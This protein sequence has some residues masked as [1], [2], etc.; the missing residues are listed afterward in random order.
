M[1]FTKRRPSVILK[2]RSLIKRHLWNRT[3]KMSENLY[4]VFETGGVDF[5]P[6][7]LGIYGTEALAKVRAKEAL[8]TFIPKFA[9]D[10]PIITKEQ[11]DNYT[12]FYIYDSKDD[13]DCQCY[14]NVIVIAEF[15]STDIRD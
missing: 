12:Y 11:V 2:H 15:K 13:Y 8:S 14:I 7:L 1:K 10:A 6:E 5:L 4:V 3:V 9:S